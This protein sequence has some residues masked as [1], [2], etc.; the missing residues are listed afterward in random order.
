[1]DNRRIINTFLIGL[2]SITLG[3]HFLFDLGFKTEMVRTGDYRLPAAEK[4]FYGIMQV[5]GTSPPPRQVK[6]EVQPIL[7]IVRIDLSA[8]TASHTV[9]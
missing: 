8:T 6:E 1:M 7:V 5:P 4:P 3:F 9:M 2:I